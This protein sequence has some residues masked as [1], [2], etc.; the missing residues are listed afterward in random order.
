MLVDFM[1][2][3]AQKCGT[4]SLASQLA[5]HPEI[6]FCKI[7]EP[8]YFHETENWQEGLEDYHSLYSPEPGQICGEA[9]TMYTF[10]PEYW[11]TPA[12]LHAYN[13]N[14]KLIYIMRQPVERVISNYTHNLVRSLVKTTPDIAVF[15]SPSYINRSRYAVQIRPYIQLFGRDNVLL[16]LFDEY[17]NDQAGTLTEVAQF[18]GVEPTAFSDVD[19]ADDH[20]SVGEWYLKSQ[21]LEQAVASDFFQSVRTY[22]P[23]AIRQP[24]RRSMA[25]RVEEKPTFSPELRQ[26]I[27]RWLEDDVHAL[28]GLLGRQLDR[29]RQGYTE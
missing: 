20:K 18:L 7:K 25:N 3:G 8:G 19:D 26:E 24:I 17:V 29:W 28:E 2:I 13:P 14:L 11:D 15:E 21:R 12:R 4:T 22:I 23:N 10:L 6:C 27:W 5:R 9:S 1:M 16:L